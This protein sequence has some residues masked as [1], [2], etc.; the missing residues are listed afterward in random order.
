MDAST[1]ME[2]FR[3][4]TEAL[5]LN[6]ALLLEYDVGERTIAAKL[7]QYLVGVFPSHDV[8]FEYNRRGL[9]PKRVTWTGVCSESDEA[10]V[11]PDL[12]VHRRGDDQANLVVCE[13]KKRSAT[14]ALLECDRQKLRAM[15][16]AFHYDYALLVLVPTGK[17][18]GKDIAIENVD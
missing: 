13:I 5:Q 6:D 7:Q 8:D 4:A 15:K 16:S 14:T 9:D 18:A 3:V 11:L 10:L 2:R 1:I 12:V 17:D